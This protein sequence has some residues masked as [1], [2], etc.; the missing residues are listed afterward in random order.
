MR[1]SRYIVAASLLL[2]SFLVVGCMQPANPSDVCEAALQ[3]YPDDM[4]EKR[5]QCQRE[6]WSAEYKAGHAAAKPYRDLVR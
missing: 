1:Y 4:Y 5:K 2:L 3:G 6:V